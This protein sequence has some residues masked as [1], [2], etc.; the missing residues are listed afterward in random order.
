MD[1]KDRFEQLYRGHAHAVFAYASARGSYELAKEAVEETFVIAW[2]RLD[3]LP[4][5]PRAWLL[6]VARRVLSHHYRSRH[7]QEALGLRITANLAGA[8]TAADPALEVAERDLTL[9]ALSRLSE[10]DRDVLCLLAWGGLDSSRAARV[11]GCTV[12]TLRV[13]LHRARRRFEAALAAEEPEP[14]HLVGQPTPQPGPRPKVSAGT[15]PV[16]KEHLP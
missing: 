15:S 9:V 1:E 6:G 3:D 12:A 11:L 5:E 4:P 16:R 7:R 14:R 2:R 13:R 8:V 10:A